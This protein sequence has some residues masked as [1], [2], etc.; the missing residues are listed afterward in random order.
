MGAAILT[1]RVGEIDEEQMLH[2]AVELPSLGV[3]IDGEQD[4]VSSNH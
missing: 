1:A 4:G 2:S 3:G